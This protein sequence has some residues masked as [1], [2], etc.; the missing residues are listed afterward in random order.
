[1]LTLK[2]GKKIKAVTL[3]PVTQISGCDVTC[4][5]P[6]LPATQPTHYI[7]G[8]SYSQGKEKEFPMP[9]DLGLL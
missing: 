4:T 2:L 6:P 5:P 8:T 9:R 3:G 7:L 1:M